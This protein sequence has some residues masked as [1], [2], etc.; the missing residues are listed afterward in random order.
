MRVKRQAMLQV[1]GR[2]GGAG[3]G[4]SGA[5]GRWWLLLGR[6]FVL[7]GCC[8]STVTGL[9][10]SGSG[11]ARCR[12]APPSGRVGAFRLE[13]FRAGSSVL[14]RACPAAPRAA[15]AAV[16]PRA[17]AAAAVSRAASDRVPGNCNKLQSLREHI[18]RRIGADP[19]KTQN[20]CKSVPPRTPWRHAG[21]RRYGARVRCESRSRAGPGRVKLKCARAAGSPGR[22]ACTWQR[23][24][25][26]CADSAAAAQ[27][28]PTLPLRPSGC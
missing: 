6:R 12:R 21:P 28:P 13:T 3:G 24:A 23:H 19:A 5:E 22:R 17:A 26:C 20:H 15:A 18:G 14:L 4:A 9:L 25:M 1:G 7:S 10:E 8:P 2:D 11:P 27:W 16:A